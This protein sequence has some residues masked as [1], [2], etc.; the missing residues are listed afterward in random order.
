MLLHH[1]GMFGVI[2]PWL[3]LQKNDNNNEFFFFSNLEYDPVIWR[4]R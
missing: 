1:V 3:G 2:I 4:K